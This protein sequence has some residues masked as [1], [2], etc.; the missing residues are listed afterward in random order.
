MQKQ[1]SLAI[2]YGK[3]EREIKLNVICI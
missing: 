2:G 3:N 1:F